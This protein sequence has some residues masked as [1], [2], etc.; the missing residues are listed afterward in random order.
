MKAGRVVVLILF[1][2]FAFLI[3]VVFL[4]LAITII[5]SESAE[6]FVTTMKSAGI[7]VTLLISSAALLISVVSFSY[8]RSD[9]LED[10][11]EREQERERSI[12]D[13]YWFR[14]ILVPR[15]F[16]PFST[17]ISDQE[18]KFHNDS[19]GEIEFKKFSDE[20]LKIRSLS[21]CFRGQYNS[22]A[23]EIECCLDDLESYVSSEFAS[24]D[25]VKN[26]TNDFNE[27]FIKVQTALQST[28]LKISSFRREYQVFSQ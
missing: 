14:T 12:S 2:F 27:A 7:F 16:D 13:E 21:E 5:T 10:I 24:I 3:P 28:H 9:R 19:F 8:S 18:F 1:V 15:F 26:E 17:F 23:E 20:L 22:L 25:Y 11:A 6:E 4:P